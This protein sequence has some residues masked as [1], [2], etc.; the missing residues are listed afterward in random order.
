MKPQRKVLAGGIA[1]AVSSLTVWALQIFAGIDV[2]AEQAVA[3]TTIITFIV[4]YSVPNS[5]ETSNA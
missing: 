4:Q 3:I 5:Q 2:P 1:G